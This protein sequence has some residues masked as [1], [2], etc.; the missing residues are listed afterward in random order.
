MI[1]KGRDMAGYRRQ[2]KVY[3]LQ[4]EDEELAGLEV[5]AKGASTGQLMHLMNLSALGTRGFKVEDVKEVDGLFELF[6]SKV[7]EWNLEDEDGIPVPTT[8]EGLKGQDLD[9]VLDLV[10]A[11]LDA[12]IGVPAPLGQSSGDGQQSP[13]ESIPM[14]TLLPSLAS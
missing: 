2:P 11:W 1:M 9:F 4:F 3:V 8:V 12:V 10:F 5:K 6:A 14:E 7:T 13:E